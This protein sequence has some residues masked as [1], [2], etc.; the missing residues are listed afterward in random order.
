MRFLFGK[1][2]L[3]RGQNCCFRQG[4][5]EKWTGF[6]QAEEAKLERRE[7]QEQETRHEVRPTVIQPGS[8][9][10]CLFGILFENPLFSI[11]RPTKIR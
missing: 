7:L 8:G 4:N 1:A 2:Y 10:G 11:I 5:W 3:F 9:G 6:L